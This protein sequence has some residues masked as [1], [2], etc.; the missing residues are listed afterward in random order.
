MFESSETT[1]EAKEKNQLIN[2]AGR[3]FLYL[4]KHEK[5]LLNGFPVSGH[6]LLDIKNGSVLNVS[7]KQLAKLSNVQADLPCT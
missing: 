4:W 1:D 6:D 3:E 2:C 5:G 7:D